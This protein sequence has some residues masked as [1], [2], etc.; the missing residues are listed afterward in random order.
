MIDFVKMVLDIDTAAKLQADPRFDF[1]CRLSEDTGEVRPYPK[2]AKLRNLKIE[3][4]SPGYCELS[5]SIHK[6]ARGENHSDFSFAS[7]TAAV[8]QLQYE[9]GINIQRAKLQNVEVW[10]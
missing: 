3:I 4:R 9:Y 10:A 1:T 2:V 7:V 8:Q 6:F 5:G